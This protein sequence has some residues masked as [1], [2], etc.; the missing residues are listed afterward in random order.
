MKQK[1]LYSVKEKTPILE[2]NNNGV[3]SSIK[4]YFKLPKLCDWIIVGIIIVCVIATIVIIC[5]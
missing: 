2:E 5:I 1:G 3:F 4:K